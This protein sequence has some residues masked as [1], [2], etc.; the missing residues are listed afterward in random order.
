MLRGRARRE[1]LLRTHA[2]TIAEARD[3]AHLYGAIYEPHTGRCDNELIGLAAAA[4]VSRH[5][6]TMHGCVSMADDNIVTLVPF[7]VFECRRSGHVHVCEHA[8]DNCEPHPVVHSDS[9]DDVNRCCISGAYLGQTISEQALETF[10]PDED[11]RGVLVDGGDDGFAQTSSVA[12][13]RSRSRLDRHHRNTVRRLQQRGH[14]AEE[15]VRL[16][17]LLLD[18]ADPRRARVARDMRERADRLATNA[19]VDFLTHRIRQ[20]G[21]TSL[22]HSALVDMYLARMAAAGIPKTAD[23][24]GGESVFL[25]AAAALVLFWDELSAAAAVQIRPRQFA[26]GM[27][28]VMAAGYETA[29]GLRVIPDLAIPALHWLPSHMALRYFMEHMTPPGKHC[30]YQTPTASVHAVHAVLNHAI[31]PDYGALPVHVLAAIPAKV[32]AMTLAQC[33]GTLLPPTQY[34]YQ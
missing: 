20:L 8:T 21:I 16:C 13:A 6:C 32:A 25:P 11:M 22:S 10:G 30:E 27:L 24:G 19:V 33:E 12:H 2:R 1:E 31:D 15:A 29:G 28:Y 34:K 23:G 4:D 3:A 14:V 18:P 7:L 17:A 26:L 9:R 5:R